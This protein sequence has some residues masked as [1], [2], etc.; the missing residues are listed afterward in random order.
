MT[1]LLAGRGSDGV[2][3]VAD[4]RV[5]DRHRLELI[6]DTERK[7]FVA[8]EKLVLAFEGSNAV[9]RDILADVEDSLLFP[10]LK[11]YHDAVSMVREAFRKVWELYA[12]AF[13]QEMQFNVFVAG[14]R[15]LTSGPAQ[16]V[17]V[18]PAGLVDDVP[19]FQCGGEAGLKS[20]NLVSLLWNQEMPV[21][22]LWPLG[23]L[24]CGYTA[25]FT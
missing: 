15:E 24:C 5:I 12:P 4:R 13:P 9:W 17:I 11:T 8:A 10:E 25:T 21:R 2:V 23:V 6:T 3:I 7:A 14:L 1:F 22:D 20:Q 18:G 19:V 16:L